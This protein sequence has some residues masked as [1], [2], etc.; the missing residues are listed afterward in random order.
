[1]KKIVIILISFLVAMFFFSCQTAKPQT[2]IDED[3]T[4][5]ADP[6]LETEAEKES[7]MESSVPPDVEVS[8]PDKD[9][10]LTTEDSSLDQSAVVVPE[11][12]FIPLKTQEIKTK[13]NTSDEFF[14]VDEDS[15]II[16]LTPKKEESQGRIVKP[17]LRPRTADDTTSAA[18]IWNPQDQ[19]QTNEPSEILKADNNTAPPVSVQD[20]AETETALQETTVEKTAETST[21]VSETAVSET[22]VSETAETVQVQ[23][24]IDPSLPREQPLII[25]STPA[26]AQIN[27]NKDL[28]IQ[29][30][31]PVQNLSPIPLT[32]TQPDEVE[33]Q[34]DLSFPAVSD[35]NPSRTVEVKSNQYIDVTYPG[36]G[37][38]YIG[39]EGG[40]SLLNYFGRKTDNGNTVFTLR[41]KEAGTTLLH[42]YKVD[43]LSGSYIDD[44]LEVVVAPEISS[45]Q[46]R[47]Q[48]PLYEMTSALTPPASV[49][50]KDESAPQSTIPRQDPVWSSPV[51]SEPDVQ[52]LF[53]DDSDTS[54]LYKG[55]SGEQLLEE[56][57]TAF[58]RAE[59]NKALEI[60][61]EFL[62]KSVD[63][64]DEAWF[65]KG[66]I[67][68]TP[69]DQRNIRKAVEAYELLTK[70]YPSSPLWKR[71][72][73]RLTYLEKFYFSIQ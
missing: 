53:P 70:A 12:E 6:I 60:L 33:S 59:Y 24:S 41:T 35:F 57:K 3:S 15:L 29:N 4:Q 48:V 46:D 7:L 50:Q 69:S 72:N 43:A 38:V 34:P 62:I 52:I 11:Q 56:A 68:E 17:I 31:S 51:T 16:E 18:K 49:I 14:S 64:L 22:A 20:S 13:D 45:Q 30:A 32:E 44:Y 39:E 47:V 25:Q 5:A 26:A 67:Y 9:E 71:A 42:F 23:Q 40:T 36:N 21:V 8:A 37:W 63:N 2:Q 28:S 65:L 10:S 55:F 58:N 1:M 61:D 54:V 66:Q 19:Q 27:D 73:D